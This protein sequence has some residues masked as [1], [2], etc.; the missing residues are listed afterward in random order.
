MDAGKAG[1]PGRPLPDISK[2]KTEKAV[3]IQV[4]V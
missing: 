4:N 1:K 3:R 2:K